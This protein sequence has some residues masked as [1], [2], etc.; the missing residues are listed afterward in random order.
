MFGYFR[1]LEEAFKYCVDV[2]ALILFL[3]PYGNMM[4]TYDENRESNKFL[5]NVLHSIYAINKKIARIKC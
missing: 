5:M 2:E 4:Q 1:L 3:H